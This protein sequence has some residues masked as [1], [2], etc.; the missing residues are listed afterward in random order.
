MR[1]GRLLCTSLHEAKAGQG[2]GRLRPACAGALTRTPPDRSHRETP[3][4]A[5]IL[6]SALP[7]S[8]PHLAPP[9]PPS[10]LKPPTPGTTS[11][12]C[13]RTGTRGHIFSISALPGSHAQRGGA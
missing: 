10:L 8:H 2:W 7:S 6:L 9:A 4:D 13:L 3:A 5:P 12:P 1:W 11:Q